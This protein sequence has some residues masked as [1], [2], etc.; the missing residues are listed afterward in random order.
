[1][2]DPGLLIEKLHFYTTSMV[3]IIIIVASFLFYQ[4]QPLA[5]LGLSKAFDFGFSMGLM[6]LFLVYIIMEK[7]K[8]DGDLR[9]TQN[10]YVDLLKAN[11]EAIISF[12]QTLTI[13]NNEI[14]QASDDRKDIYKELRS[15]MKELR[16]DVQKSDT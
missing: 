5:E 7:R 2:F 16:N 15:D 13:L 14:K 10:I 6:A 4:L 12:S 11:T 8:S 3:K 9:T 1:M